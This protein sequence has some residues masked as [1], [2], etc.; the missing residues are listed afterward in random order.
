ML[1]GSPVDALLG[2]SAAH[3]LAPTGFPPGAAAVP[4]AGA[5]TTF[6]ALLADHL[7]TV[8]PKPQDRALPA[9]RR[10]GTDAPA[11]IEPA[12]LAEIEDAARQFEALLLYTLLKQMWASVPESKLFGNSLG[13][14]FYREM[15]L[16]ALATEIAVDGPGLGIAEPL[17]REMISLAAASA[18]PELS[19]HR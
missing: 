15:W 18:P 5:A 6:R 7:S 8:T 14:K 11:Q 16:E 9:G 17:R 10:S 12:E 3:P 2:A 19:D 4:T 1:A 13:G